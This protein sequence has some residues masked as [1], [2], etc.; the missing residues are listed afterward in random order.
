MPAAKSFVSKS[1]T[2]RNIAF[3]AAL[4]VAA[5]T[6]GCSQKAETP[7]QHLSKANLAFEK[8]QFVEAER[9]YRE[10]LRVAPSDSVAQRQLALL[11]FEQGQARQARHWH[12]AH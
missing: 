11:Y 10:V 6:G 7:Q 2:A 5:L 9:E 3:V 1:A 12:L 8:G 4:S